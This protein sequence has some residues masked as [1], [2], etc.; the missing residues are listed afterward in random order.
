MAN[1][2]IKMQAATTGSINVTF[3][4]PTQDITLRTQTSTRLDRLQDVDTESFGNANG[5]V[6]IYNSDT[7]T[8]IQRPF[9]TVDPRTG[10]IIIDAGGDGF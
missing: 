3:A 4:K 10:R 1:F 5:A 6:L 7:D 8:Y 9:G 2:N